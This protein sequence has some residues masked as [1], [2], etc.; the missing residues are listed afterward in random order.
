VLTDSSLAAD[1]RQRGLERAKAF[2]WKRTVDETV[3]AYDTALA[4][5]A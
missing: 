4:S 1:L 3:A 5:S 2:T